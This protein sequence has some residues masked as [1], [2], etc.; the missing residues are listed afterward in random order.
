MTERF[1]GIDYNQSQL[2]AASLFQN[3]PAGQ[4]IVIAVAGVFVQWTTSQLGFQGA[5][6]IVQARVATDDL[7]AGLDGTRLYKCSFSASVA[8]ASAGTLQTATVHVNGAP[9]NIVARTNAIAANGAKAISANGLLEL[10]PGDTVDLRFTSDA[11]A[12]I[13]VSQVN[14]DLENIQALGAQINNPNG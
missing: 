8:L 13:T 12:T 11:P 9:T 5:P 6:N 2:P 10:S 3:L 4:A 1:S 7:V 14:L